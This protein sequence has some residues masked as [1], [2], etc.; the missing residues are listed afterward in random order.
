[1]ATNVGP[2][3]VGP[4]GNAGRTVNAA[5]TETGSPSASAGPP[6]NAG[7]TATGSPREKADPRAPDAPRTNADPP[8]TADLTEIVNRLGSDAPTGTAQPADARPTLGATPGT[9]RA[10]R[11]TEPATATEQ[12]RP[13]TEPPASA[14]HQRPG[15]APT[16]N[17]AT[18]RPGRTAP[19]TRTAGGG[20]S[21][22]G[23]PGRSKTAATT[24]PNR[25]RHN[26][27]ETQS[28]EPRP[29]GR[30]ISPSQ[31]GNPTKS[32]SLSPSRWRTGMKPGRRAN[33]GRRSRVIW[34]RAGKG[35]RRRAAIAARS[36]ALWWTSSQQPQVR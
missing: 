26:S 10:D 28:R 22:A 11:G 1:M 30:R 29:T 17:T 12:T 16:T 15:T 34:R 36:H 7:P 20:A 6:V 32:G 19:P 23:A 14:E 5:P 21:P 25:Q 13:T 8:V 9:D 4:T 27:G 18:S 33:P 35:L 3:T 31:A 24:N 2:A